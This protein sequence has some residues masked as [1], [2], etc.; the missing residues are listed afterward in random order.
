MKLL[1]RLS[2]A[3]VLLTH[4]CLSAG[5]SAQTLIKTPYKM[6]PISELSLG[7]K[8][9]SLDKDN[10]TI[11]THA[12]IAK[13]VTSESGYIGIEIE[14]DIII[15]S[16]HQL[17]YIHQEKTWKQA[18]DLKTG[19]ALLKG[20]GEHATIK[21]V[22]TYDQPL[23]L[24]DISVKDS[25]NYFVSGTSV[26]THNF[27]PFISLTLLFGGG[28]VIFGG[29]AAGVGALGCWMG[30]KAFENNK[31]KNKCEPTIIIETP[32]G[33]TSCGGSPSPLP[34]PDDDENKKRNVESNKP[35]T[36]NDI[37]NESKQIK[38]SQK[39]TQFEKN[40]DFDTAV[41]DFEKMNLQNIR[42]YGETK[43]GNLNDGRTVNVRPDSSGKRPTLEITG[44]D[45]KV[46]IRYGKK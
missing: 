6:K 34:D 42:Q 13:K 21:Q 23:K 35:K 28:E 1:R 22:T 36:I 37:I 7:D 26:L 32:F 20:S 25:H 31:H 11:S 12:V 43:V 4:A 41:Q 2:A 14:N 44:G 30:I 15:A 27:E 39:A 5:F 45:R 29:I 40:G 18:K 24:F 46:K 3:F 17:F 10:S 8:V 33:Q 38:Q 16:K 9:E 19:D